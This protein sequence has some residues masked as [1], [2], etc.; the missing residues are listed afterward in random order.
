MCF[1]AWATERGSELLAGWLWDIVTTGLPF[2]PGLSAPQNTGLLPPPRSP[3][4]EIPGS[5]LPTGP[6]GTRS[7]F[8][9]RTICSVLP[10][11]V[12]LSRVSVGAVGAMPWKEREPWRPAHA[13]GHVYR[14]SFCSQPQLPCLRHGAGE[15]HLLGAHE[16]QR[17]RWATQ[18]R[19]CDVS[20]LTQWTE[21]IKSCRGTTKGTPA[22]Q[23]QLKPSCVWGE[24]AAPIQQGRQPPCPQPALPPA[25]H[26][27]LPFSTRQHRVLQEPGPCDPPCKARPVPLD[28][29]A[30]HPLWAPGQGGWTVLLL[31]TRTAG[32]TC[33]EALRWAG[34]RREPQF[35]GEPEA[36]DSQ[37]VLTQPVSGQ[38]L[39][40]H[41]PLWVSVG[42]S[43]KLLA[44][45]PSE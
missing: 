35:W 27:V 5:Q 15:P 44:P 4:P 12:C 11:P 36:R 13:I 1:P 20:V 23:Q 25:L 21:K 29:T 2:S 43:P 28:L 14:S 33:G 16:D 30:C 17:Q 31:P 34:G 3:L 9:E 41:A 42:R 10:T 37:E 8:R 32:G 19:S 38:T 22:S 7:H 24:A 40:P 39:Q 45:P 26:S 6:Q 18:V